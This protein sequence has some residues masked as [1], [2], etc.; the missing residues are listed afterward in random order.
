MIAVRGS[1]LKV[2]DFFCCIPSVYCT[3]FSITPIHHLD[4][5]IHP[6]KYHDRMV[7]Y[8]SVIS[9][10]WRFRIHFNPP[11]WLWQSPS[12]SMK[13]RGRV[14]TACCFLSPSSKSS[15]WWRLAGGN[16]L[17]LHLLLCRGCQML[18][19]WEWSWWTHL[20]HL[21]LSENGGTPMPGWS[22]RI[23]QDML[24]KWRMIWGTP[25]TQDSTIFRK[26][27]DSVAAGRIS[28]IVSHEWDYMG[29]VQTWECNDNALKFGVLGSP[30]WTNP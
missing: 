26:K 30:C 29:F 8:I 21:E 23:L 17:S 22:L 10:S 12:S 18:G 2:C 16:G 7:G 19:Q 3:P 14:G 24:L 15:E 28:W 1:L 5:Q 27:I 20:V 6:T 13:P 4:G 11:C 25:M 9:T